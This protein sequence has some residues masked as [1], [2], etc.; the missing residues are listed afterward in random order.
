MHDQNVPSSEDLT[1]GRDV[2]STEKEID[3]LLASI[4]NATKHCRNVFYAL[5]LSGVYILISAYSAKVTDRVE[6]PLLKVTVTNH[7]FLAVS[8]ILILSMYLYLHIHIE[9][10]RRKLRQYD[11]VPLETRYVP[12]REFLF[13]WLFVLSF[14]EASPKAATRREGSR[15]YIVGST[16]TAIW[17]FAPAILFI[18]WLRFVGSQQAISLVPCIAFV[19]TLYGASGGAT[20][21]SIWAGA[22]ALLSAVL[23][24]TTIMSVPELKHMLPFAFR[25][26]IVVAA[27]RAM[28][29]RVLAFIFALAVANTFV[30]LI[31][32]AVVRPLERFLPNRLQIKVR[33]RAELIANYI[34]RRNRVVR[35]LFGFLAVDIATSEYPIRV[36]ARRLGAAI[37]FVSALTVAINPPEPF[38]AQPEV[39][40]PA[41][42]LEHAPS[43]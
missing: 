42:L 37:A 23:I 36:L 10:L 5:L 21:N 18:L 41:R 43:R 2:F 31:I 4:E 1:Q 8:P 38:A 6:L 7:E 14:A 28:G 22:A 9:D 30:R 19:A 25:W 16:L 24:I 40:Q 34:F 15:L 13:P 27:L 3:L 26:E 39:L 12:K 29:G 17:I 11:S 33:T 20:R 35:V 32:G